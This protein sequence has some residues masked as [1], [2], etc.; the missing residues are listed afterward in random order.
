MGGRIYIQM[1]GGRSI[2]VNGGYTTNLYG[3]VMGREGLCYGE[4][5]VELKE[6]ALGRLV[7]IGQL[8]LCLVLI[9]KSVVGR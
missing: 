3:I 8:V 6:W 5:K 9:R 7:F 2:T 1:L 4:A